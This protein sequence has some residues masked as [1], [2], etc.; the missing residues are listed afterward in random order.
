MCVINIRI[1]ANP[2]YKIVK[3]GGGE[4]EVTEPPMVLPNP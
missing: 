3:M 4:G 2:P 1:T